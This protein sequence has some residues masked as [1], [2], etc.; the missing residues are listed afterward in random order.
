M[1]INATVKGTAEILVEG[2][3]YVRLVK[4]KVA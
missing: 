4:S 2:G 1:E 3:T